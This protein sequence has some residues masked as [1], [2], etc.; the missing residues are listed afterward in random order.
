V[1][2]ACR[3]LRQTYNVPPTQRVEVEL[4][5]TSDAAVKTL[6]TFKEFMEKIARA[7]AKIVHRRPDALDTSPQSAKHGVAKAIVSSEIE[8]EMPLGGL[9]DPAAETARIT[10]DIEKSKKEVAVVE[11]KLGNEAF[12]AKAPEEVVAE[13]RARL[14]EELAR[15]DRL[16]E[17][18]KTIASGT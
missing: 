17:A 18:L 11:K 15:Q 1:V 9:I 2:S 14:A 6:N 3:M 12:V 10:K 13:Q 5:V 7:N 8:L 4:L 16:L